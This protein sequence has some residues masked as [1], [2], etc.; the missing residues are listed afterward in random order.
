MGKHLV[1]V[2]GGH[3][4]LNTLLRLEEILTGGH[5]A[6]LVSPS[7]SHYYSGMGPGMLSGLYRAREL[8]FNVARMA[9]DRGARFLRGSA[10]HVNPG[11][12]LLVLDSGLE[13]EYDAISFNIGS[14]VVPTQGESQSETVFP[15][16]PIQNFL[17]A[18]EALLG[19]FASGPV[20]L[21]VAGG[22]IAAL[23]VAGNLRRL[24]KDNNGEAAITIAA[25]KTF[26]SAVPETVRRS[27]MASLRGRDVEVLEGVY[28]QRFSENEALLDDG[29]S[30]SFDFAFSATGVKPPDLFR[31]SGMVVAEDGGLP[32]NEHLQNNRYPMLFGGGDCVTFGKQPLSRSGVH[33]VK[34]GEVLFRNL[35]AAIRGGK[36]SRYKPR[37]TYLRIA[38]LGDGRGIAWRGSFSWYGRSAM[39]LKDY[40]DRRFMRKFQVSGEENEDLPEEEN[41]G[42]P[43]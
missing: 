11:R 1:L 16:K 36:L 12:N 18:R 7:P 24:A 32:V 28:V 26:L 34:E 30:L 27:A 29:R 9:T 13:V 10:M 41:G 20:K 40:I 4:H 2:G 19:R 8:R 25:G 42:A 35:T 14:T 6:T 23:E 37:E 15:V 38:N 21:L 33:A 31:K 39:F 22:G 3:A 5:R 17:R 43:A